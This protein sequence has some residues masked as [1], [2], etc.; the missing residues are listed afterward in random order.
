MRLNY[1]DV[2]WAEFRLTSEYGR[3]LRATD[4]VTRYVFSLT[5]NEV[6][7]AADLF[8]LR[9]LLPQPE[10][11]FSSDY[12]RLSYS[13]GVVDTAPA[14]ELFSVHHVAPL[15]DATQS[16]EVVSV[17]FR[18]SFSDSVVLL[19]SVVTNFQLVVRD[20]VGYNESFFF[21]GRFNVDVNN[22]V[23]TH[24]FTSSRTDSGLPD[25]AAVVEFVRVGLRHMI[26][27]YLGGFTFGSVAFGGK[28]R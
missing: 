11:L 25:S 24:D 15:F 28:V 23:L 4:V 10:E 7:F 2:T 21:G 17:G 19:D 6:L 26:D 20:V 14:V 22:I 5:H 27:F 3:V 8:Y 9:L 13:A 1:T 12:V 18:S 16:V